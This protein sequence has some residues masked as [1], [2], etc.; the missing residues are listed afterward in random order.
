MPRRSIAA[1]AGA[2]AALGLT[3]ALA[4]AAGP[5]RAQTPVARPAPAPTQLPWLQTAS[6]NPVGIP[7]GVFSG[8]Y[9]VALAATGVTA[10]L[11]GTTTINSSIF[12]RDDR[13]VSARL[14]YYPGEVALK[15]LAVGLSLGAHR[16][17][18]EGGQ[19]ATVREHDLALTLGLMGSYNQLLGRQQ[20]LVLG[21]GLGFRR[22][23]KD[24]NAATSPLRQAY[25]DGRLVVGFAF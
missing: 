16:A 25:P 17:E 15:G 3:V 13:W 12:D 5:A 8:E 18:R 4:A 23:L 1:A 14:M 7:F 10:A 19:P 22:V 11:G 21:A 6:L 20:R 9:E 2:T 24:V